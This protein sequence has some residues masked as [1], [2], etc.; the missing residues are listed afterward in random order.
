[1]LDLL[2]RCCVCR[3]VLLDASRWVIPAHGTVQLVVQFA[4]DTLGKVNE[5]L[6]FEVV[7]GERTNKVALTAAC[8]YPRINTEAKCG[9]W[10][11][12]V[13][14]AHAQER[15]ACTCTAH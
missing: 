2:L 10:C 15:C 11:A 12:A 7:C 3:R 9:V 13:G 1:M 14:F 6:C 4:S 5:V 8:D